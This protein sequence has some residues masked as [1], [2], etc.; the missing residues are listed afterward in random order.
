VA[1]KTLRRAG[2]AA[3]LA[4][5]A[6]LGYLMATADTEPSD[7]TEPGAPQTHATVVANSAIIVFREGLE[8]VL[9]FA[10]VTTSFLG[11]N[12]ARRR[13]VVAGAGPA[14]AATVAT[15]FVVLA[16]LSAASP[17]GP[18]PR[19]DHRLPRDHRPKLVR[20]IASTGPSRSRRHHRRRRMLLARSR[21]HAGPRRAPT[22][23]ACTA[24]ASRS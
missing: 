17:L 1:T 7:P 15:W 11:A 10:A 23:P 9:I 18:Q 3:A 16:A 5:V 19:G 6:A 13:P 12:R 20:G 21:A 8:A 2:W 22:S 24:T 14:F 4:A